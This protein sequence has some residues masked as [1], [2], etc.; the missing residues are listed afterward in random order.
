MREQ[1]ENL[2]VSVGINA[3]G[4]RRGLREGATV[5]GRVLQRQTPRLSQRCQISSGTQHPGKCQG[6]GIRMEQREK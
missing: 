3:N 2:V 6:R 1:S 4:S 5:G